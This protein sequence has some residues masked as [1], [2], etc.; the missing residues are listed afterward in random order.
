MNLHRED[1]RQYASCIQET[2]S[3]DLSLIS[4]TGHSFH[5]LAGI[6]DIYLDKL[7]DSQIVIQGGTTVK[8]SLKHTY[9]YDSRD[10]RASPTTG[11]CFRVSSEIAGIGGSEKFIKEEVDF[12]TNLPLTRGFVRNDFI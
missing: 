8:S 5:Y 7:S 1:H 11:S 3:L 2:S 6:R 12:Q 10:D 4:K 9:E